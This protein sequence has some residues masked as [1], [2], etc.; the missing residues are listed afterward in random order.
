MSDI[1][2]GR[3]D[4]YFAQKA[5]AKMFG[6]VKHTLKQFRM[7]NATTEERENMHFGFKG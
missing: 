4:T 3:S 1:K 7:T 5:L 6:N 2:F